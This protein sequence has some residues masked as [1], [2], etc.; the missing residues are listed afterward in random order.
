MKIF[1]IQIAEY[2]LYNCDISM[3]LDSILIKVTFNA[4][5]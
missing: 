2:K 3:V 5:F 4:E 1:L